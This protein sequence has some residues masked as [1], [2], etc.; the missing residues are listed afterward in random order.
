MSIHGSFPATPAGILRAEQVIQPH[1]WR[2]PLVR[3]QA[4]DGLTGGEVYFKPECWQ[5]TGS[6]K[7][8]GAICKL[9]SL[10][11]AQLGRG[12]VTASAGNGGLGL[13]YASQV[14]NLPPALIFV[15]EN[16]PAPKLERLAGF[17][18]QVRRAGT[19]YDSSHAL[20]LAY[21]QEND[22]IYI[23][24]YDDPLVIAG[25]GTV[26]LELISDLPAT[27]LVLVPVGGG[28]LIAGIALVVKAMN[29]SA[30]IVGVQPE[31]SPAAYLSLKDGLPYETYPA[32][33]TICDGLAG[34][35]GRVPFELAAGL[36]D[37]IVVVPEA[38][39]R[40]AVAWL[41]T[42]EQMVVEGSG[43]IAIAPLLS[44]QV[45]A[46]GLRT[47]AVLTGRNLDAG[48][49]QQILREHAAQ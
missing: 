13:A 26:G 25:Q 28:G 45:D 36:I 14:L 44:G 29:P 34:G 17:A 7:V 4:L 15:P 46:D 3:C 42:Q 35:F 6:F 27:D 2:T 19:D 12:V 22:A 43:A 1:V 18:C 48:L 39:I 20:A 8:R 30:R 24:A 10:S 40:Q 16:T 49:L 38:T 21:A 32:E 41:L 9:A 47:V 33:A 37:E 5:P 23:S 11:P 31:A